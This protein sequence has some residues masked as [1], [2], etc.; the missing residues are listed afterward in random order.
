M[1]RLMVL[2]VSISDAHAG[3]I[4]EPSFCSESLSGPYRD[5]Y[6]MKLYLLGS[7][8]PAAQAQKPGSSAEVDRLNRSQ[9]TS[10]TFPLGNIEELARFAIERY[11]ISAHITD[12]EMLRLDAMKDSQPNYFLEKGKSFLFRVRPLS[13]TLEHHHKYF[14][15]ED[16]KSFIFRNLKEQSNLPAEY[17]SAYREIEGRYALA[18]GDCFRGELEVGP[19]VVLDRGKTAYTIE[20]DHLELSL[21]VGAPLEASYY[22]DTPDGLLEDAGLAVRIKQWRKSAGSSGDEPK[23]QLMIKQV[24]KAHDDFLHRLEYGLPISTGLSTAEADQALLQFMKEKLSPYF[25]KSVLERVIKKRRVETK[26]IGVPLEFKGA[27]GDPFRVGFLSFDHYST[28]E[29]DGAPQYFTEVEVEIDPNYFEFIRSPEI[30][31][32]FMRFIHDLKTTFNAAATHLH[33]HQVKNHDQVINST[34]R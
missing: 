31:P 11:F 6:E 10:L 21:L 1:A 24:M 23:K 13:S 12:E 26:R 22:F 16:Q 14:S 19:R 25:P 33:K 3:I 2:A 17:F 18:S 34:R 28:I 9:G 7:Q 8:L 5:E 20:D 4:Q 15:M 32:E 27:V 29:S 30:Y